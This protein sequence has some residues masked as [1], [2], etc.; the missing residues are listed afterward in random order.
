VEKGVW[1]K[2]VRKD[3]SAKDLGLCYR[4]ER[5]VYAKKEK[6]VLIVEGEKRRSTSICGRSIEERIHPCCESLE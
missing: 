3:A 2:E 4:I 1:K 6:G 5:G